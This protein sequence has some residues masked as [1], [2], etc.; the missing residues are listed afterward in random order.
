MLDDNEGMTNEMAVQKR[1]TVVLAL[2]LFSCTRRL[3][4]GRSLPR[5]LPLSLP[6]LAPPLPLLLNRF[7]P[8]CRTLPQLRLKLGVA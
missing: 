6:R 8:L 3:L 7:A 2:L 5:P 1:A 4:M